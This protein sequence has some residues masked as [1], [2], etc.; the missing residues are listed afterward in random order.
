M[1]P[2]LPQHD[3]PAMQAERASQIQAAQAALPWSHDSRI[4]PLGIAANLP[5]QYGFS[6]IMLGAA[7]T[8]IVD[9]VDNVL[10]LAAPLVTPSGDRVMLP[11]ASDR[12]QRECAS[13]LSDLRDMR[14]KMH[15][16]Q[17]RGLEGRA[18]PP[19]SKAARG[20]RALGEAVEGLAH[21]VAAAER[22]VEAIERGA[23]ALVDTVK[24][25][26]NKDQDTSPLDLLEDLIKAL[27]KDALRALLKE[28]GLYGPASDLYQ[29]VR[30]FS[31]PI[32]PSVASN[33]E[34]DRLFAWMRLGGPNPMVIEAVTALPANLP[35][36]DAMY[37]RVMGADDTLAQAIA[38]GRLFLCDY[39]ALA[40]LPPSSFPVGAKYTAAPLA[41]FATPAS[42]DRALK[43]VAIQLHQTPGRDNPILQPGD[44]A[45]WDLARVFVSCA[46]AN[47]H[48]MV[49]H[50][51]RTH[52][53]VEAF[54]VTTPRQL[55]P[56]HPLYVL[57]MPHLEGTLAINNSAVDS[58]IAPKGVVDRLLA[59][60]IEG[61]TQLAVD[62]ALS[63]DLSQMPPPIALAARGVMD[64]SALP[65]FPY[66]DDALLLWGA[67]ESWVSAYL[68][69]YYANDAD[70]SGDTELAAWLA[71]LASPQGGGLKGVPTAPPSFD[72]LVSLVATAIFTASVQHAAVNFPQATIMSF[73]PALP[74]ALYTPPPSS[75]AVPDGAL[76]AALPPLEQSFVQ[77]GFLSLLGGVYFT[78]LG[79]YDRY[80]R[81]STF[82]DPRVQGPLQA[83]QEALVKV[84]HE[85][86]R[87]NLRRVQY[88]T[89]LPSNVPQSIN[90]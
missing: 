62:A 7:A 40:A 28:I 52:L 72:A 79:D 87:S 53:V 27:L 44:G 23:E 88:T 38:D 64:R 74:L 45:A 9:I 46:D 51:G 34:D 86:G 60:T 31:V 58:L 80:I 29:Y 57:L 37:Q 84:E 8:V 70:L 82:G 16:H 76:L 4:A 18:P 83:F 20:L 47:H 17:E 90:I 89:L 19:V 32:P 1:I 11:G 15:D 66:R 48:E 54:A 21:G 3:S 42:G 24:Q 55:A 22:G 10:T 14:G 33:F 65:E 69:L 12:E 35:I 41:L 36:T 85:I 75:R 30:Q 25:A 63:A 2:S 77:L 43:P 71:E 49:S 26:L 81:G 50:L 61:L 59:G 68:S 39:A 13:A 6:P 5:S 73:T 78:R 67:I 56:E